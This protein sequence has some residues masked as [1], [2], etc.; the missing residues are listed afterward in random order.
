MWECFCLGATLY[1][2]IPASDLLPR[3]INGARPEQP[4]FIYDDLY[5]L[6]LNCW[7][8]DP[9]DRPT[10][11]EIKTILSQLLTAPKH[12]LSYDLCENGAAVIVPYHLP[13]LENKI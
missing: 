9:A 2:N 5:Q 3:I 13:L 8:M 11:T 6:F 7:E 4:T 12:A 10:F 1:P